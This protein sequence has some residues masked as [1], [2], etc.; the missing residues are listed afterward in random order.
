MLQYVRREFYNE[1]LSESLR[2]PPFLPSSLPPAVPPSLSSSL[3]SLFVGLI[4]AE[5]W[6][7]AVL[8]SV[9]KYLLEA[10]IWQWV[11]I[12]VSCR[13]T[14]TQSCVSSSGNNGLFGINR[15][16]GL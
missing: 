14:L 15:R 9:F 16:A 11:F 5:I 6:P 13:L 4:Q 10:I 1:L 12:H 2:L 3:M 8:Y 7:S